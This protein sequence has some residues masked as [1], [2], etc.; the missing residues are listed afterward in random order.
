M[1]ALK[2]LA[3]YFGQESILVVDEERSAWLYF[4]ANA[5][6]PVA[7][8]GRWQRVPARDVGAHLAWTQIGADYW[9]VG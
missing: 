1:E 4:S 6:V 3:S 5:N 7:L 8:H 9:A 2:G